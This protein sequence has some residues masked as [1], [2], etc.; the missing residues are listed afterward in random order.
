MLRSWGSAASTREASVTVALPGGCFSAPVSEEACIRVSLVC[1]ASAFGLEA[2]C[3]PAAE[4][5]RSAATEPPRPTRR[6]RVTGTPSSE[7]VAFRDEDVER[8]ETVAFNDDCAI[9]LSASPEEQFT[10]EEEA[11]AGPSRW[12]DDSVSLGVEVG[13]LK[14]LRRMILAGCLATVPLASGTD[15]CD[16]RRSRLARDV[17]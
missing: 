2:P 16:V 12:E 17:R 8:D 14:R 1:V 7:N 11:A 9:P 13:A 5:V 6:T 15:S 4:L 3:P 10:R